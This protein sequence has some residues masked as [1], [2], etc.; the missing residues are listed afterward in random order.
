MKD[1]KV[2]DVAAAE[3]E[4][5]PLSAE[6]QYELL[7]WDF[8]TTIADRKKTI[9]DLSRWIVTLQG[10]IVGFVAVQELR[11]EAVFCVV[12]LLVGAVGCLLLSGLNQELFIHRK[13]IA[14]LQY[15]VGGDFLELSQEHVRTFR[16]GVKGSV[17]YWGLIKASHW[18]VILGSSVLAFGAVLISAGGFD[19][20]GALI[21]PTR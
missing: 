20:A 19:A 5:S 21:G 3:G 6:K 11:F 9:F 18:I 7:Y 17:N 4:T 12:P 14:E 15:R 13:N 2:T 16:D 8:V 10:L 1:D